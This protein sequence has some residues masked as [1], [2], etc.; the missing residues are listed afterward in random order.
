MS[1]IKIIIADDHAVVRKGT[2]QILEED[3]KKE[4]HTVLGF[5]LPVDVNV[6]ATTEGGGDDIRLQF[7]RVSG[8]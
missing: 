7:G 4:R 5:N 3:E 1:N 6:R 8:A 2:R